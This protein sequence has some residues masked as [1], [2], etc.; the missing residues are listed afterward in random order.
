MSRV[1]LLTPETAPEAAKPFLENALK[2]SGF[3]PNLLAVLANAPAA[4]HGF[5][6]VPKV[7]E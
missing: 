2:G 1:P 3:I 5:F 4:E 6:G 7:I